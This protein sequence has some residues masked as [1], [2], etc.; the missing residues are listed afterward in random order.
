M[1]ATPAQLIDRYGPEHCET[2]SA[3]DAR[4]WC[5]QLA[6]GHYENFSVLTGL[7]PPGLRDDF[8]SVYAFCR[9]ADDLGD[10]MGERGSEL[11]H[12]WRSELLA[13]F[14]GRAQ[15]P[16]FIALRPTIERYQ[17]PIEPFS[18]LISAFE[19]D[20]TQTRYETWADLLN[21]C[22][23]SANPVGRLVLM[24][25]ETPRTDEYFTPSDAICT[26]LQLTNHLQDVRRDILERDRIYLPRELFPSETFEQR[27]IASARQGWG[28]DQTILPESR[29]VIR[30]CVERTWELYERGEPL[31]K[32][33][34][35]QARPVVDLLAS[36]GC[37]V[38]R[39]VEQWNYETALHRPKLG[40]LTR[41]RL[42][43]AAWW[44][45]RRARSRGAH[46]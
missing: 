38:L 10:E 17:L 29:K 14:D 36:G 19:L 37:H 25:F 20:Q 31:L 41:M 7:V 11:L 32:Q 18:D 4:A 42:L 22:R 30:T 12:W 27:L 46:A 43:A 26:A 28:V 35:M 1:T 2:M 44:R 45:A 8:A 23:L 13:C 3:A 39:Q 24:L 6:R 21:Y 16:V 33:L 5:A 34:P 15:H 9:W 40:S